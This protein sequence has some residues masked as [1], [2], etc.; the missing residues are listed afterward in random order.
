MRMGVRERE[1]LESR[2][3][4]VHQ[5]KERAS[6]YSAAVAA[7]VLIAVRESILV[8]DCQVEEREIETNSVLMRQRL[9]LG[10]HQLQ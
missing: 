2:A 1:R 3:K 8:K 10:W 4:N 9:N 5:G 7:A 6:G